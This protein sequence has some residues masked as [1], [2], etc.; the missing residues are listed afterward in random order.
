MYKRAQIRKKKYRNVN[1]I[2]IKNKIKFGKY[3]RRIDSILKSKNVLF[4]F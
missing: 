2:T 1:N 3:P 4:L